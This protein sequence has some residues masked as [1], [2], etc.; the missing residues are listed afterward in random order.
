MITPALLAD[1]DCYERTMEGWCDNTHDDAFTHTVRLD[2]PLRAVEVEVL[3]QPSPSYAIRTARLR[4]LRGEVSTGVASGLGSLG[5]TAM[6]AGFSRRVAEATGGGAG[7]ALVIDAAIEVA[8]LAR[9]VGKLPRDRAER[10]AGNPREAWHLDTSGWIDLPDSCFTY[11]AAGRALLETRTVST[12][13]QA[14]FY[15]PRPGQRRVFERRKVARLERRDDRLILF[16]AMHDNVHGFELTY[17][18]DVRTGRIE[19]ADSLVSRLPYAGICSEPQ[20]NIRSLVGEF[21]DA[22]LSKRIQVLLG[23]A[24]GCA[25]LYDLTADLLKLLRA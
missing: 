22:G 13:M 25:Q 23:G 4:C 6:V 20:A 24:A 17:E 5:G 7:A 14:D 2:D 15:S 12:P 10:A 3:A 8:R 1:R 18:I 19:R 16:H 11:S 9:Q 21:A